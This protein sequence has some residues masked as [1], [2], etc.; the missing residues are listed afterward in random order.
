MVATQAPIPDWNMEML[1]AG[2]AQH[3][4][5]HS[6]CTQAE[7]LALLRTNEAEAAST[8]RN[9]SAEELSA[10]R[11]SLFGAHHER[12]TGGG[13]CADRPCAEPFCGHPIDKEKNRNRLSIKKASGFSG[14]FLIHEHKL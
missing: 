5:A 6:A 3:A 7:V 9:L 14:A 8:V 4:A 13:K 12:T 2:N 1:H 11:I 10:L